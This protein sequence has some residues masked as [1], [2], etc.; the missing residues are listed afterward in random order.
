MVAHAAGANMTPCSRRAL[1]ALFMPVGST[2]NGQPAA[3]PA[4]LAARLVPGQVI[5]APVRGAGLP[6]SGQAG[7]PPSGQACR[8]GCEGG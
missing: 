1:A 7:L 5:D 8:R 3:L 2:F 4:A 6:P